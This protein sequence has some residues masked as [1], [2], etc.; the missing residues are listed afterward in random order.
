LY[1]KILLILTSENKTKKKLF[2]FLYFQVLII[3]FL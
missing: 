2:T 3:F 1:L